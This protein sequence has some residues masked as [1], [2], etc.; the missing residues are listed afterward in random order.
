[1]KMIV[2]DMSKRREENHI[3]WNYERLSLQR[4]FDK[5]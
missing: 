2:H 4:K 3:T 1:M 5:W